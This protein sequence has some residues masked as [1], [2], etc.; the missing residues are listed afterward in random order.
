M[1]KY[2]VTSHK[3]TKQKNR[4]PIADPNENTKHKNSSFLL[5]TRKKKDVFFVFLFANLELITIREEENSITK[6]HTK[7]AQTADTPNT[8]FMNQIFSQDTAENL[9]TQSPHNYNKIVVMPP[10]QNIPSTSKSSNYKH[11]SRKSSQHRSPTN[12]SVY[13][14]RAQNYTPNGDF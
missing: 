13:Q 12:R 1:E 7:T 9:H 14:N 5:M 4:I 8:A 6:T 3:L 10:L 11:F 2:L